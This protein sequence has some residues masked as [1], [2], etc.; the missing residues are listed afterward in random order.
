MSAQ[1]LDFEPHKLW[2][3]KTLANFLDV[4][5]FWVNKQLRKGASDPIP[6]LRLGRLV[7]FDPQDSLFKKW[8]EDHRVFDG[9]GN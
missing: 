5:V 2:D 4:S 8:L 3:K 1:L 7:R 6:H 9:D